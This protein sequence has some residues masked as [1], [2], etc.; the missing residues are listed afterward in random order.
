MQVYWEA[1]LGQVSSLAP[2]KEVRE[3]A[4]RKETV[5]R[6]EKKNMQR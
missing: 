1:A 2:R 6:V 4:T 5:G 3:I